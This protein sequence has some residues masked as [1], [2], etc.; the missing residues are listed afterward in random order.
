[1]ARYTESEMFPIIKKWESTTESQSSFCQRHDI[2][3][4]TFSYWRSRYSKSKNIS[5]HKGDTPHFT[6]LVA[7]DSSSPQ[8]EIIYP[9]GVKIRLSESSSL[10]DLQALIQLV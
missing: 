10:A 7:K 8:L 4:S 9:N 3:M 1:M 5:R 6:Q 2:G